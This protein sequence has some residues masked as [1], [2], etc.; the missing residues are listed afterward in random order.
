M[1]RVAHLTQEGHRRGGAVARRPGRVD[2]APA[3]GAAGPVD[4]PN[5]LVLPRRAAVGRTVGR[6]AV[7]YRKV[8][9]NLARAG[10]GAE[11]CRLGVRRRQ[12]WV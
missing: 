6:V 8:A 7:A 1:A 4:S 11:E 10:A 12:R 3:T 5:D 9:A 2:P